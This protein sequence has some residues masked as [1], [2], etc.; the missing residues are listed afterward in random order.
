MAASTGRADVNIYIPYF[1]DKFCC[2]HTSISGFKPLM[3]LNH[4]DEL[5]VIFFHAVIK[6]PIVTNFLK[7]GRKYMHKKT[8]YEFFV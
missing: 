4:K 3:H 1:L 2:R 5:Q 8:A 7:S 6:E